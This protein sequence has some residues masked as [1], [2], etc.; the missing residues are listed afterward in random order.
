MLFSGTAAAVMCFSSEEIHRHVSLLDR[1]SE[2]PGSP[3]EKPLR[4]AMGFLHL[5]ISPA[6]LHLRAPLRL[7]CKSLPLLVPGIVLDPGFNSLVPGNSR[8]LVLQLLIHV[9][10]NLTLAV[11]G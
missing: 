11:C 8:I 2:P 9:G 7:K 10:S 6:L 4:A 1:H 5:S 3:K